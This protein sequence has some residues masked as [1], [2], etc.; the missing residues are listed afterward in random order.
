MRTS[1]PVPQEK[2]GEEDN[3]AEA[4][5]HGCQDHQRVRAAVQR[6]RLFTKVLDV[7][8]LGSREG[9]GLGGTTQHARRACWPIEQTAIGRRL[10]ASHRYWC[11]P[12]SPIH[13]HNA[14][15]DLNGHINQ[16]RHYLAATQ[17]G[18]GRRSRGQRSRE[19]R[20]RR[21]P[22]FLMAACC[23]AACSSTCGLCPTHGMARWV[24]LAAHAQRVEGCKS[25]ELR[26]E[27]LRGQDR[28]QGC[29][30]CARIANY[31]K[32]ASPRPS[33]LGRRSGGTHGMVK[34]F[35][36][37]TFRQAIEAAWHSAGF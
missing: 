35:R 29:F 32:V 5:R 2:A 25:L 36:R 31:V 14:H 18:S 12:R 24:Q 16:V 13:L 20:R 6:D 1:T 19:R 15:V 4:Q 28:P 27:P 34:A 8:Y 9:D 17:W 30:S 10:R 33:R 21:R 23:A 22:L 3:D 7:H 11:S 26:H 37:S